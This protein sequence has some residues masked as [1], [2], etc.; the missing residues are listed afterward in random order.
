MKQTPRQRATTMR[1][2][3]AAALGCRIENLDE[4]HEAHSRLDLML[5]RIERM[6]QNRPATAPIATYTMRLR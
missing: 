4:R 2:D 3:L 1:G 6:E 5:D